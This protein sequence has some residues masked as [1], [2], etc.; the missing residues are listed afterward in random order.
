MLAGE[1][2]LVT[3]ERIEN[4]AMRKAL[5]E[6]KREQQADLPGPLFDLTVLS[7][8]VVFAITYFTY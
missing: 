6:R 2:V 4:G 1:I 3:Q 7:L 8:G 5:R